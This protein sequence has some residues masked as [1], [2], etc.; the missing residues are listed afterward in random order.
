MNPFGQEL[1]KILTQCKTSGV[2]SYAGR[3]AY[4]QLDPDLRARLEF[5]SLNIASQY[6]ALK[7]TIL[8]RTEGAVDVNILRFGDLLGKK[9]VS[10]PNF[11]DGILPHLWDDYGKVDW[12]VYQPTQ[13]DYR[14]LAGT[15]DEYLQVFQRQEE[16]QEHSPQHKCGV[17]ISEAMG[18]ASVQNPFTDRNMPYEQ[19]FQP[20]AGDAEAVPIFVILS[21]IC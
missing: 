10:N 16:A 11:S 21:P 3:S 14:L 19:P 7:L 8:N 9:K 18:I 20:D 13:A 2:V 15:V 4:I 6:N 17:L 1:R 5:V 12:Y